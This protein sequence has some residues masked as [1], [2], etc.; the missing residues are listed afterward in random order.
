M[1]WGVPTTYA[2]LDWAKAVKEN[3]E[4]HATLVR[5]LSRFAWSV[6]ANT[7]TGVNTL[8]GV[9]GFTIGT[10]GM[11][12]NPPPV[13]GSTWIGPEAISPV[14][15][16]GAAPH[17]E[18]SRA[19]R[20]MFCA[21]AGVPETMLFGNADVGNL[22]TA[23]TLDRPTEL[24]MMDRQDTWKGVLKDIIEYV[25]KRMREIQDVED[26]R[27]LS[28]FSDLEIKID[29]DFPDIMTHELNLLMEALVQ[30]HGTG[31]LHPELLSRLIME[32]LGADDIDEE[33]AKI[34]E[35]DKENAEKEEQP[36]DQQMAMGQTPNGQWPPGRTPGRPAPRESR[37]I[38]LSRLLRQVASDYEEYVNGH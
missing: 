25:V 29:V 26:I 21:A 22:A 35:M 10:S 20:L 1:K 23:K 16:A 17:P 3:L 6:P 31:R 32:A 8:K 34:R 38:E 33:M 12:T 27:G 30:A 28:A 36:F 14:K 24:M 9:L 15:T 4:D 13:T 2:G 19:L 11:E 18:D 7:K 5:A 37:E